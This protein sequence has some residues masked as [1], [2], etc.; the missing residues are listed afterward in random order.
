MKLLT[1]IDP[2]KSPTLKKL[3]GG[4]EAIGCAVQCY[5]SESHFSVVAARNDIRLAAKVNFQIGETP[6][7]GVSYKFMD[8][9]IIDPVGIIKNLEFDYSVNK[10]E[11]KAYGY[12]AEEA[13]KRGD[14]LNREYNDGAQWRLPTAWLETATEL[15]G[16]ID[17]WLDL[18][19]IEHKRLSPKPRAQKSLI[20]DGEWC[21]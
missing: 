3:I 21:G 2:P 5:G 16:W 8:A 4:L 19:K 11:A 6:S 18:L 20:P 15:Y 17:E 7:G 1:K 14:R 13:K 10:S 9:K 12:T